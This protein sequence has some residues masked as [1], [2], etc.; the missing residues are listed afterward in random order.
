MIYKLTVD[1]IRAARETAEQ[2]NKARAMRAENARRH[3]HYLAMYAAGTISGRE[4]LALYYHQDRPA[5]RIMR[6]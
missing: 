5:C 6:T 4:T 2:A 1:D 3:A